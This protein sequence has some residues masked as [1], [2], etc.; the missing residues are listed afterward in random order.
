MPISRRSFAKNAITAFTAAS[1]SPL[2]SRNAVLSKKI[3]VVCVGGH[4]DDPESGC[5][6]TLAKLAAAGNDVTIIYLT[7]GEAGI[8]GTSHNDAAAIR[9]REARAACSILNAKPVF[10]GQIDGDTIV[11]NE[12]IHKLNDL[13]IA[14]KPDLVYIYPYTG[15]SSA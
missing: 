1:L 12:W 9:T 10:A 15:N 7:S 2:T 3:K 6:G 11:N 14:E 5:G 8:P 4:P 13:I